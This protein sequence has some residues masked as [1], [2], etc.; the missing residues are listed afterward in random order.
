MVNT[1]TNAYAEKFNRVF[2]YIEKHLD[3][4]L[5][6][7]SLSKIANFSKYHFHRQF[8]E[9]AGINVFRYIQL[10]RM[11]R[12]SYRL[13]FSEHT[14]IIDIAL[15]AGFENP[16]SFS[17][18]FK[19]MFG[20]T[21]S[22]FRKNPAWEPWHTQYRAP[23]RQRRQR[24][25]VTIKEFNET[26]VAVLEHRG[27]PELVNNSVKEFI[28]WRKQSGLSPVTTS[29]TLGIVY[30]NPETTEPEEFRF[31]ICGSVNGE[32]PDN[33]QGVVNKVIPS[34]RCAVVRHFGSHNR[35]GESAYYLYR[36]W[37][38]S[39]G[40]ELRDFPLFFHY[41]NLIPE[42][43]EHELVTDVYLPLKG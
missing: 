20:Q 37:L 1:K 29:L 3:E 38:P 15:E 42:T 24:M 2:D 41:L 43:P 40:E 32:I 25:E 28:A 34:G 19:N 23:T 7:E 35:I 16:E 30:D 14:R 22:Q 18:A 31:D 26:R 36:E 13:A 4:E 11:R 8:S 10:M 9:Y 6:V 27:A 5:S 39:S 21:P 12:A 33:S 17:R